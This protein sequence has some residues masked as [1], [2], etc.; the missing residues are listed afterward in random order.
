MNM[1]HA[2]PDDI[3]S[4]R[5]FLLPFDRNIRQIL[6]PPTDRWIG[7]AAA[8]N[9][10]LTA[11]IDAARRQTFAVDGLDEYACYFLREC[12]MFGCGSSAQRFFEFIGNIRTYNYTFTV[13]HI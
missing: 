7:G 2:T 6:G 10:S 11:P 1:N 3:A 13:C 12:A 8:R 4:K 5:L 9:D